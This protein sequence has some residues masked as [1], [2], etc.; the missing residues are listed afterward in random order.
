MVQ[1]SYKNRKKNRKQSFKRKNTGG[2]RKVK[3]IEDDDDKMV[4]GDGNIDRTNIKTALNQYV[5]HPL[6]GIILAAFSNADC[7]STDTTDGE[8][9][10]TNISALKQSYNKCKEILKFLPEL[11]EDG[12]KKPQAPSTEDNGTKLAHVKAVI[13]YLFQN[14][15]IPKDSIQHV[16]V[17]NDDGTNW[18]TLTNKSFKE[19]KS[20][21]DTASN[22]RA[23]AA[24]GEKVRRANT[25]PDDG[26]IGENDGNYKNFLQTQQAT[27]L[28][29]A[30]SGNS[31]NRERSLAPDAV[32]TNDPQYIAARDK[33]LE[34]EQQ[35]M[36]DDMSVHQSSVSGQQ[37]QNSATAAASSQKQQQPAAAVS[38]GSQLKRKDVLLERAAAL[39]NPNE[40]P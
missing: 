5:K 33:A 14:V 23:A 36:T 24:A 21:A 25:A 7:A 28:D 26:E 9:S 17:Q 4:G 22:Q 39:R 19:I 11:S 29:A 40:K 8:C 20:G 15:F 10:T 37:Q 38:S 2:N 12:H 16:Y 18:T 34:N 3:F 27:R 32:T 30:G 31:R 35:K 13:D 1:S 6:F